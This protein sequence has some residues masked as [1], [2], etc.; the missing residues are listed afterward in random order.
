MRRISPVSA[1]ASCQA[2]HYPQLLQS[3]AQSASYAPH[4]GDGQLLQDRPRIIRHHEYTRR[5]LFTDMVGDLRQRLAFCEADT[6][7]NS[8]PLQH[9][10]THLAAKLEVVTAR[11][12]RDV[13]K[14]FVDRV[15]LNVRG[16][17]AERCD[18]TAGQIPVELVVARLQDQP[19]HRYQRLQLE[20]GGT[21]RDIERLEL[22][23]P[24]DA[25]PVVVR[26]DGN[27][28][29][30]QRGVEHSF[31]GDV[32]VVAVYETDHLVGT[33]RFTNWW[34]TAVTTPNTFS[35]MPSANTMGL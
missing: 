25:A 11:R 22:V 10:L 35:S 8:Y 15:L 2:V 24:A 7:R 13:N 14:G 30:L 17:G 33:S 5:L 21:H 23:G 9:R 3:R 19:M 12:Q 31:A 1:Q 26:H 20:E 32:E 34:I 28:L 29:T 16:K 27:R 4:F 18:N 6:T